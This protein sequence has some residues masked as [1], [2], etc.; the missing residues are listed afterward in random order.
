MYFSKHFEG[1]GGGGG[2]RY[3]YFRPPGPPLLMFDRAKPA[4][5]E[6][7]VLLLSITLVIV[8][9]RFSNQFV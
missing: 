6:K 8:L 3:S 7:N 9:I 5:Q 4:K 1:R 2:G